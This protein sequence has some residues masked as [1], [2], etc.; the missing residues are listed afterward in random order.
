MLLIQARRP[1]LNTQSDSVRA[2]VLRK[3]QSNSKELVSI[4]N[5][6]EPKPKIIEHV[7]SEEDESFVKATVG[8]VNS[9]PNDKL[10]KVLGTLWNTETDEFS[11]NFCELIDYAKSLPVTK[12]SV[13]K[14][15]AKIFD[16]LGLLSGF[17]ITFKCLFQS[18]CIDKNPSMYNF[19]VLVTHQ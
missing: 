8:P 1:S 15:T 19:I 7:V 11:F 9:A 5:A 13:L 18:F 12:R 17:T 3:W 6:E 14:V 10:V 2:K 16:P 4:F